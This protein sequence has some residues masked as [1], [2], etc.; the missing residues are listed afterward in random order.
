MAPIGL[1]SQIALIILSVMIV[2]TFVK[3][4]LEEVKAAEDSIAIY[5]EEQMKVETV[6]KKLNELKSTI[7]AI[8]DTDRRSL[9]T[10]MPNKVDTIAVPRDIETIVEA[11]GA[12]LKNI[13]D[14]GEVKE[15]FG[16][17]STVPTDM[18]VAHEFDFSIEGSY[19]QL[20]N[21]FAS[22]EQNA[23]PLEIHELHINAQEGGFMR[24]DGKIHTYSRR[25]SADT[26]DPLTTQ[27]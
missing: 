2:I 4:K 14:A 16:E 1:F 3:P 7:T 21:V 11:E 8:S 17:V 5:Q 19:G 23:Y 9:L 24:A 15:A 26:I 18:P 27:Q 6:N 12:L 20:K 22:F 10:Y 25:F 13:R